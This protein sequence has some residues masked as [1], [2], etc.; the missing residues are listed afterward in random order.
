[1]LDVIVKSYFRVHNTNIPTLM[2]SI[3]LT[4]YLLLSFIFSIAQNDSTDRVTCPSAFGCNRNLINPIFTDSEI[5]TATYS[6]AKTPVAA[7]YHDVDYAGADKCSTT[8]NNCSSGDASDLVYKVYYPS[9][10]AYDYTNCAKLPVIILF[11]GGG[12]VDCNGYYDTPD[13]KLYCMEFAKRGYVA[14]SVEYRT[15]IKK[16]SGNTY[17][18]AQQMLGMWRAA[19]DARGAVRSIIKRE[20]EGGEEYRINVNR[21]FIGGNSA[22]SVTAMNVAFYNKLTML[23]DAFPGVSDPDVLDGINRSYYYG[24]TTISYSIKGVLNL[25]GGVLIPEGTNIN[26]PEDFF[27]QTGN[28]MPPMIAF[29][30]QQDQVFNY[31][32][33]ALLFPQSSPQN[34]QFISENYCLVDISGNTTF[35]VTAHIPNNGY[36]LGSQDIYNMLKNHTPKVPTE[37]YLDTDMTHGIGNGTNADFGINNPTNNNVQLYIVQRTAT[38]F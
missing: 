25:W 12:F 32:H 1:M 6:Y 28:T 20:T 37:F 23:S 8:V 36:I 19:Q 24:E 9:P 10:Q 16:P 22:G 34:N 21:I 29:C 31:Q 15:G 14:V 17:Y 4:A 30:G 13:M 38:F 5:K 11:H 3:L 26:S 2:R 35:S 18:S 33:Q 27:F 7:K